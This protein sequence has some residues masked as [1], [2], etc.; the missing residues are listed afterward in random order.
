MCVCVC[1]SLCMCAQLPI[2]PPPPPQVSY[3]NQL[4]RQQAAEA[5][6]KH[7]LYMSCILL[8]L[9]EIINSRLFTTV[10]DTHTHTHTHVVCDT[11]TRTH[12]HVVCDTHTRIRYVT[13][14]HIHACTHTDILADTSL[15]CVCGAHDFMDVC[16]CV[17]C[18]CRSVTR[19]G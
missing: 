17:V 6:R 5:R 2:E 13:H 7:P 15:P 19:W 10:R 8:L 9:T 11:H 16:V 14:T 3:P 18:A 12:T 4:A 1:V